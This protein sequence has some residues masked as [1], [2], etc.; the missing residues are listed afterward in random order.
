MQ[1]VSLIYRGDN[2]LL[3]YPTWINPQHAAS[4][5]RHAVYTRSKYEVLLLN[6]D[7]GIS[8]LRGACH[9]PRSSS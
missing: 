2:E 4:T 7:K 5:L 9:S 3:R 1:N 6:G 8:G